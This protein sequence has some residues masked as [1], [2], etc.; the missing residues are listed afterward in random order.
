[1]RKQNIDKNKLLLKLSAICHTKKTY[2][3]G[4]R[5]IYSL[6]DSTNLT[7]SNEKQFT[8]IGIETVAV[9]VMNKLWLC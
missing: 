6:V 8:G 1:V 7:A 5:E 4:L 9:L 2:S 3:T